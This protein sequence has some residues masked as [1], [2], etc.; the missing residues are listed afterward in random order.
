MQDFRKFDEK[1]LKFQSIIKQVTGLNKLYEDEADFNPVGEK[2]RE[3][4]EKLKKY[5][6]SLL[7]LQ[8]YHLQTKETAHLVT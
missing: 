3:I 6:L 2:A 1:F 4:A 8:H 7:K 5:H